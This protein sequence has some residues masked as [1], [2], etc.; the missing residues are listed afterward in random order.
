MAMARRRIAMIEIIEVIFRWHRGQAL[1]AI[2]RSLGGNRKT[3]R[4]YVH[5]A[6]AAGLTRDKPLPAESAIAA[7][8]GTQLEQSPKVY[9]AGVSR[10]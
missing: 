10:R 9:N 8:I 4:K 5:L 7:L 6:Q 3:I 1:S 2:E